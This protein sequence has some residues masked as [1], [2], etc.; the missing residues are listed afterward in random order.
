[1]YQVMECTDEDREWGSNDSCDELHGE[2]NLKSQVERPWERRKNTNERRY[3][4]AVHRIA[5]PNP[6]N[7]KVVTLSILMNGVYVQQWRAELINNTVLFFSMVKLS[8]AA[9]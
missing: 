3:T 1:M 9:W 4:W 5:L 2:D 7:G 6:P 8:K